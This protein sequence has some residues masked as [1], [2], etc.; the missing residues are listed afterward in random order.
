MSS[1]NVCLVAVAAWTLAA[2]SACGGDPTGAPT[3]VVVTSENYAALYAA[4]FCASAFRCCEPGAGLTYITGGLGEDEA[5]CRAGVQ[6]RVLSNRASDA[7]FAP[8]PLAF[9]PSAAA[10]R[11][12]ALN[13]AGCGRD[14]FYAE[15]DCDPIDTGPGQIGESCGD[16]SDCEARRDREVACRDGGCRL[17]LEYSVLGEPCDDATR[18]CRDV[19]LMCR[20]GVCVAAPLLPDGADCRGASYSCAS[21]YCDSDTYFCVP[22]CGSR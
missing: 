21:G 9:V 17:V 8:R 10:C 12:D 7:E 2:L 19:D 6:R 14:L 22:F 18:F 1:Q 16:F 11:I 4:A 20:A 13:A 5:T 3:P 15:Q